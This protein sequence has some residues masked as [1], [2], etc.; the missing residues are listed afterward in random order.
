M[1]EPENNQ[2]REQPSPRMASSRIPVCTRARCM[3][4][5]YGIPN[6][7]FDPCRIKTWWKCGLLYIVRRVVSCSI[8]LHMWLFNLSRLPN[9]SEIYIF[10]KFHGFS[11][12]VIFNIEKCCVFLLKYYHWI[13][14]T[15]FSIVHKFHKSPS[16]QR[17][18]LNKLIADGKPLGA[19]RGH[20]LIVLVVSQQPVVLP[21]KYFLIWFRRNFSIKYN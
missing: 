3:P 4:T 5:H 11:Q 9:L 18:F 20:A 21:M 7:H 1:T 12:R 19:A 8:K 17:Y 14:H 10:R 16:F 15:R 2:A 13:E 6:Q